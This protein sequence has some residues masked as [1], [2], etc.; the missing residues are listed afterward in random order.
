MIN[1]FCDVALLHFEVRFLSVF[2]LSTHH[3]RFSNEIL[4]IETTNQ[5]YETEKIIKSKFGSAFSCVRAFYIDK[6]TYVCV[7]LRVTIAMPIKEER[8]I[9]SWL[10]A[11]KILARRRIVVYIQ[12]SDV[13]IH[14][15]HIL[16]IHKHA[17]LT[18]NVKTYARKISIL[19]ARSCCVLCI[20]NQ[21]K[22]FQPSRLHTYIQYNHYYTCII[23][24]KA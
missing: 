12:C 6:Y 11:S 5:V 14:F 16:P 17:K 20:R 4:I 9:F 10:A 2:C 21:W 13:F 15:V 22:F 1:C 23:G 8:I 24:T 7:L 3:M 18:F 19:Q